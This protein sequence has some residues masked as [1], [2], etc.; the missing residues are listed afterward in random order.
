M[1]GHVNSIWKSAF[2]PV[3]LLD[4]CKKMALF[5]NVWHQ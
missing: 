1:T 2:V 4:V 3:S 5:V